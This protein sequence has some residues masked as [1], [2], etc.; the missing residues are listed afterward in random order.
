MSFL[1]T[2][3][4]P[5]GISSRSSGGPGYSTDVV[6]LGSGHEQRNSNWTYPR[7]EFD[8]TY[9]VKRQ[10]HI[11]DLLKF[12]H[13]V[14]GRT[15]GFRYKDWNDYKSCTVL[16]TPTATDCD[17]AVGDGIDVDFQLIKPY[18]SG[19]LEQDREITKP[20]SGTVL[21]SIAGITSQRWSVAT[22]TGVVTFDADLN[23]TITNAVSSGTNTVF[24]VAANALNVGDS[25]WLDSFTGDWAGLNDLRYTVTVET[26]ATFTIAFDT[27]AFAAYA[28]NAGETHTI[29]QLSED[30]QAGFEFDIPCRFDTDRLNTNLVDYQAAS[31]QTPVIEIKI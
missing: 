22:T 23:Y 8:I 20:V 31:I 24:T 10:N 18:V 9:G 13:S 12:F 27:S 19:V 29:P 7:H 26:A 25:V 2:P 30:V 14:V 15:H 5:E 21:M 16:D 1:E 17:I 3:R 4:F 28:A 6:V 11:Y